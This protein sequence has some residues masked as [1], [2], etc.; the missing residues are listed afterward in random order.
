M[1][2]LKQLDDV[3]KTLYVAFKEHGDYLSEEQIHEK[4]VNDGMQMELKDLRLALNKIF[5]DDNSYRNI[6]N[7]PPLKHCYK[8]RFEGNVLHEQGGYTKRQESIKQNEARIREITSRQ[9]EQGAALVRL[10]RWVA[11][12][13]IAVVVWQIIQFYIENYCHLDYCHRLCPK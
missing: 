4:M 1:E 5:E 6:L 3:L 2:A 9:L 12:G 10:N 13:A 11:I 7:G 8:I